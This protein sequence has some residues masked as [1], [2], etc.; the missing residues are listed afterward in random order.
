MP[1]ETEKVL[2]ADDSRKDTL[3]VTYR[4]PIERHRAV[5]QLEYTNGDAGL[6]AS[7]RRERMI[8]GK[9]A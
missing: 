6:E 5:S 3:V 7:H 9:S 8:S 2:I 4:A 1:N